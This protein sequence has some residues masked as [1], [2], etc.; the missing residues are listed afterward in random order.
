[1][2]SVSIHFEHMDKLL[3]K[4]QAWRQRSAL[5][6]GNITCL[7]IKDVW[8]AKVEMTNGRQGEVCCEPIRQ[9]AQQ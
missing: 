1:M 2:L 3:R 7:G 4:I 8:K 5:A 6:S 9:A